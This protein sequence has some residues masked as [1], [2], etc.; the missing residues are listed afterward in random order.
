[1]HLPIHKQILVS[2]QYYNVARNTCVLVLWCTCVKTSPGHVYGWNCW[3]QVMHISSF[4]GYG[5]IALKI[6]PFRVSKWLQQV[7][8]SHSNTAT[9]K[10]KETVSSDSSS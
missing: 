6:V 7:Q 5:W 10:R 1:M 8:K 3:L 4:I 9:T 2:F